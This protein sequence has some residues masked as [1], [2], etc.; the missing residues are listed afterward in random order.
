MFSEKAVKPSSVSKQ[1]DGGWTDRIVEPYESAAEEAF[2]QKL[3]AVAPQRP[4]LR[5]VIG[6]VNRR[7][8][9]AAAGGTTVVAMIPKLG[10]WIL[11]FGD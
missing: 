10:V 3:V 6:A 5:A 1:S 9:I 11:R 2:R 4:H 8:Y 7:G